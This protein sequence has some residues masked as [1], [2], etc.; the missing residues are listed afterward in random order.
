MY[1]QGVHVFVRAGQ[2]DS[3]QVSPP[4]NPKTDSWFVSTT[5]TSAIPVQGGN[6]P[7]YDE[8]PAVR[9]VPSRG[10]PVLLDGWGNPIIFVPASGLH[11]RLLNGVGN[12]NSGSISQD[13]IIVSPEGAVINQGSAAPIVTKLGRPFFAS[14]G[15][16][17]DF[18]KGDD[19]IYSFEH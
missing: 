19:N 3:P 6:A 17:G 16:D 7:W 8:T 11:V 4:V 13:Y 9:G 5:A 14:A 1:P 10:V 12:Y 2:F 15:P 18:T